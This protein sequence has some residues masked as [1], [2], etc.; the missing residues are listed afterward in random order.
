MNEY[1]NYLPDIEEDDDKE[2]VPEVKQN[3]VSQKF[4]IGISIGIMAWILTF[5]VLKSAG[6]ISPLVMR[7]C[8][9]PVILAVIIVYAVIKNKNNTIK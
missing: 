3:E 9:Y 4:A 6:V 2:K 1:N 7:I 5:M 8:I